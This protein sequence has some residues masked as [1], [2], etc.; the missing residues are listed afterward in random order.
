MN[1][2]DMR[3][4]LG[5]PGQKSFISTRK[6]RNVL[7]FYKMMGT[8]YKTLQQFD[9]ITRQKDKLKNE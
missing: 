8:Y 4:I 2:N 7:S 6:R 5:I 1:Q 9:V 3:K